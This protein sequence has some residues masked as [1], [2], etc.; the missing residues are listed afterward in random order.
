MPEPA[1]RRLTLLY[2]LFLANQSAR[3][4]MRAAMAGA[5]LTGTEFAV[6]SYFVANGP[7]TL[8]QA[9]RDLG[10]PVTTLAAMLAT[11]LEAGE[12][13]RRPHPR[14]RRARLIA[15][16]PAGRARWERA[17]PRFSAAYG[18]LLERLAGDRVDP[19]SIFAALG[20]LRLAVDA[21]TDALED[22]AD[23]RDRTADRPA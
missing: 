13:E 20:S 10:F 6:L 8:S 12:F 19:E 22:G 1:Q 14:D 15:L 11:P 18:R 2:E 21:T 9:A 4:Y 23:D 7:R 17:V 3:R 5:D 16:T